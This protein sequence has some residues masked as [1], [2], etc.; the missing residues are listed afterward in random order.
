MSPHLSLHRKSACANRTDPEATTARALRLLCTEAEGSLQSMSAK[1]APVLLCAPWRPF[2]PSPGTP[3]SP[4]ALSL[5]GI[6]QSSYPFATNRTKSLVN[7]RACCLALPSVLPSRAVRSSLLRRSAAVAP[8]L[9]P[10]GTFSTSAMSRATRQ[11]RAGHRCASSPALALRESEKA[12][13]LPFPASPTE[14]IDCPQSGFPR[15]VLKDTRRPF[16]TADAN[17]KRI[18]PFFAV[19]DAREER[20]ARSRLWY[21]CL[22]RP[23][24]FKRERPGL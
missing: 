12:G 16:S 18:T 24:R 3:L 9:P 6:Q 21:Y 23:T 22:V 1:V 14:K 10:F 19:Q 11:N 17:N 2:R 13:A 7:L 20:Q 15:P 5:F 4:C 8:L